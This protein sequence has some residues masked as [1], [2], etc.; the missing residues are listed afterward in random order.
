MRAPACSAISAVRSHEPLS[1]TMISSTQSG[2]SAMTWAIASS[3]SRAGMTTP[4]CQ[5][6]YTEGTPLIRQRT[7][8]L[9]Q[10]LKG[11]GCPHGHPNDP[12]DDVLEDLRPVAAQEVKVGVVERD[13]RG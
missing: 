4:I 2:M 12:H 3:S 11:K 13:G 7:S 6:L 10:A 5:P 9:S 1:A 8:A